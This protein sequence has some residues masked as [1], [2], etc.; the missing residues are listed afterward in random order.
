M[1]FSVQSV[2]PETSCERLYMVGQACAQ[3]PCLAPW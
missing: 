2:T 1:E 3:R